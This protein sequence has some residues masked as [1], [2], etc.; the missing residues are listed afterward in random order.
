MRRQVSTR[1]DKVREFLRWIQAEALRE[2]GFVAIVETCGFEDWLIVLLKEYGCREVVLIQPEKR[3]RK[4]TDQRDGAGSE[5]VQRPG[6][7]DDLL[8]H[9]EIPGALRAGRSA[10]AAVSATMGMDLPN[11][12][13]KRAR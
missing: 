1:C 12:W 6:V 13:L 11:S 2:G 7:G 9:G 10:A 8:A 4:K 3:S 5:R